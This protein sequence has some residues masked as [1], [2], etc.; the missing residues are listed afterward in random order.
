MELQGQNDFISNTASHPH[1][2]HG[3]NGA[4][5]DVWVGEEGEEAWDGVVWEG[6]GEEEA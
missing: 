1:R 5:G 2:H 3:G 6:W 4:G